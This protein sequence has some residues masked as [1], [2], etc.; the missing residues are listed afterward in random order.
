M[1]S[2]LKRGCGSGELSARHSTAPPASHARHVAALARVPGLAAGGQPRKEH[3]PRWA[4]VG[5]AAP[6]GAKRGSPKGP[7]SK[8]SP[9]ARVS[10]E[11]IELAGGAGV[12]PGH[13]RALG[14][15]G[16]LERETRVRQRRCASAASTGLAWNRNC[17]ARRQSPLA[18]GGP[19]RAGGAAS[20]VSQPLEAACDPG[21]KAPARRQAA[22][23][24]S[25][26]ANPLRRLHP[27]PTARPAA[28]PRLWV[29]RQATELVALPRSLR[30]GKPESSAPWPASPPQ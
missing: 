10:P 6:T 7:S 29:S 19:G 11:E 8:A 2:V 23:S 21:G 18:E 25:G 30:P 17:G 20:A 4:P 27:A 16:H 1:R 15:P 5:F 24:S 9:F 14:R 12:P 26:P 22:T 28:R 3:E 13:H